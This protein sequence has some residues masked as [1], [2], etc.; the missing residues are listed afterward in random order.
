MWERF[1]FEKLLEIDGI[2]TIFEGEYDGSYVFPGEAHD[3]WEMVYIIDGSVCVCADEHVY[4]MEEN[5]IIFHRPMQLHKFN[6][7]NNKTAHMFIVS[8]DISGEFAARLENKV[9][10]LTP[11]QTSQLLSLTHYL[12]KA[13]IVYD[14][15]EKHN[16]RNFISAFSN[17]VVAQTAKNTLENFLLS[18]CSNSNDICSSD[19]NAEAAAYSAAVR[20]MNTSIQ[21][22]PTSAEIARKCGVSLT[23]LKNIFSKYAGMGIHKYFL[24]IKLQAAIKLLLDG[25]SV[26]QTA[27]MLNFSSQNYFSVVFKRE[28]GVSPTEYKSRKNLR[29]PV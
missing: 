13:D 28:T 15:L 2:Y 8:F 10:R 27:S 22:W 5:E 9:C 20:Y 12:G 26:S 29:P 11:G 6:I 16:T 24:S 1:K 7:E 21:S 17:P 14:T 4:H 18:V 23:Q 19:D 3:F 25:N